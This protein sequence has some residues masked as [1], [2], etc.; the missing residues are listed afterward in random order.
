MCTECY[1]GAKAG[2]KKY[3]VVSYFYQSASVN[4]Q[5]TLCLCYIAI[6]FFHCSSS[7]FLL[8]IIV[9]SIN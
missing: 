8:V 1:G 4:L 2:V 9:L 6:T 5:V 3:S 7:S